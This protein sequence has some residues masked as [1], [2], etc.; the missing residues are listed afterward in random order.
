MSV[1]RRFVAVAAITAALLL[2]FPGPAR[3]QSQIAP[4]P[5]GSFININDGDFNA[6]CPFQSITQRCAAHRLLFEFATGQIR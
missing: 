2:S 3:A 4:N 6:L 5:A 1:V